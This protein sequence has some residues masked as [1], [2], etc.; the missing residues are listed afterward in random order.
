ML[1]NGDN[2][3]L[4]IIGVE[5]MKWNGG[6]F[7]VSCRDY[8]ALAFR[9]SGNAT[10]ESDGNEYI[11]KTND[12]LYLPQNM[13]FTAKYTDT[14]L[15]V[16][17]FIT[18]QSDKKSE[19]FSFQNSEQ[20]YKL[21]LH[22]HLI[23]KNKEAGYKAYAMSA[24]YSILGTILEKE[25]KINL[26]PHFLKAISY[27][28]S[29]YKNGNLNVDNICQEA[30]MCATTFRKLFK[31]NYQKTPVEYITDLRIEHARNLI[32]G[33]IPIEEAAYESGFNDPKYF[34]R[35]VKKCLNCT[36][37]DLKNYGR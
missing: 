11:V 1:C 17:H 23:W 7:N 15:I 22:A 32:S 20:I 24:L 33:G 4:K 36:P 26:P 25:T 21:F 35:V 5:Y 8:S 28:N 6:I 19:V 12:I 30:G 29:N 14:E 2:P 18:A 13:S 31:N 10:I 9:I 34:A 37:R 27:I 3:I 16:I